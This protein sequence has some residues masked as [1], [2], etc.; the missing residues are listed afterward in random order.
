MRVSFLCPYRCS[1]VGVYPLCTRFLILVR[2]IAIIA[3]FVWRIKHKNHDGV[4]LW[5]MSMVADVWFGFSWLLNQL[6]KLNL[7]KRVPDVAAIREQYDNSTSTESKLPRIDVFV[8]TVD[9]VDEPILYTVNSILSILATD[10]PVE[11]YACC[12]S[13]DGGSLIHYEAMFEVAKIAELWVPFCQKHRIEP[14][15]PENYFGVKRQPYMGTMHE[16]YMS[17]HRRVRR[18]YEEFKVRIESIFTTIHKRSEAYHS[19]NGK[20]DGLKGT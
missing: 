1:H 11:K 4:W 10:Y 18:E 19:K 12:L 3:F 6:P 15:A 9:R 7:I 17:D 16:E 20:E 14:R 8:T 2:L 5:V 13:D